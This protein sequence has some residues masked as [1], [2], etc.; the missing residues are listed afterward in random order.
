MHIFL[1]LQHADA[2]YPL[3][4]P[5][6]HCVHRDNSRDNSSETAMFTFWMLCSCWLECF[7][8]LLNLVNANHSSRSRFNNSL[9]IKISQDH[10]RTTF[11]YLTGS[12]VALYTIFMV[13]YII[14]FPDWLKNHLMFNSYIISSLRPLLMFFSCFLYPQLIHS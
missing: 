14:C 12:F 8:F 4:T 7:L 9:L 3:E 1:S 6:K 11:T 10:L 2:A 13:L 5:A